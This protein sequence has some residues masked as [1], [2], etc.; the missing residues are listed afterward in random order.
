MITYPATA[1]GLRHAGRSAIQPPAIFA[2]LATPSETPSITPSATGGAPMLARKAGRIA[3]A[4]SCPQ[5]ENKLPRPSPRTPRVSQRLEV[6]GDED[7][8]ALRLSL[9][10]TNS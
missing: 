3:V 9:M 1:E 2:K 4:V 6:L 7:E 5:S 10:S 8:S